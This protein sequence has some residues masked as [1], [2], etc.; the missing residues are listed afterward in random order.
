MR[1]RV[2]AVML[3]LSLMLGES[4]SIYATEFGG[5]INEEYEDYS[6]CQG[7]IS[8]E[9]MTE[10]PDENIND[11][12]SDGIIVTTDTENGEKAENDNS[13]IDESVEA[14][15]SEIDETSENG[16]SVADETIGTDASEA[17]EV[18]ENDEKVVD[19][20]ISE[21]TEE[22]STIEE[23]ELEGETAIAV[24]SIAFSPKT[25]IYMSKSSAA[26]KISVTY[27]P[28]NANTNTSVTWAS[29]N[30]SVAKVDSEGNVSPVG[31]GVCTITAKTPN[32]KAASVK[33]H[34]L[35][36]VDRFGN[37]VTEYKLNA[38]TGVEFK[39]SDGLKNYPA[40]WSSKNDD[41][42]PNDHVIVTDNGYVVGKNIGESVVTAV[43]ELGIEASAYVNVFCESGAE[44]RLHSSVV[45]LSVG[46]SLE[47]RDEFDL[48]ELTECPETAVYE[49]SVSDETI[50]SI[51]AGKITAQK[52]GT[53]AVK[54]K[55]NIDSYG[56]VANAE[57]TL[58]VLILPKD[59]EIVAIKG[60]GKTLADYSSW[61]P[62][63]WNWANPSTPLSAFSDDKTY[64]PTI[65]SKS[66]P[67]FKT[68]VPFSVFNVEPPQKLNRDK[69]K[70]D[71][72]AVNETMNL[73]Y[74]DFSL[75]KWNSLLKNYD[76]DD[77]KPFEIVKGSEG[78]IEFTNNYKIKG[79]SQGLANIN[80]SAVFTSKR[81]GA[82]YK[83]TKKYTVP[84]GKTDIRFVAYCDDDECDCIDG[85]YFILPSEGDLKLVNETSPYCKLT[86][87]SSDTSVL[88]IGKT[89]SD[90]TTHLTALSAGIVVI[91]AKANDIFGTTET[92]VVK[93][94]LVPNSK[95]I[96][97][98]TYSID[99]NLNKNESAS[100]QVYTPN[101]AEIF[102]PCL[103]DKKG[104]KLDLPLFC[105]KDSETKN[106]I[107]ISPNN[108]ATFKS[109][110]AYLRIYVNNKEIILSTP[111][112][113]NVKKTN[114]KVTFKQIGKFDTFLNIY[115]DP[116]AVIS[117]P[118]EKIVSFKVE[119]DSLYG[120]EVTSDGED[121]SVR[122]GTITI[123]DNPDS[124]ANKSDIHLKI[125]LADY[126]EPIDFRTK[127]ITQKSSAILSASSGKM[128]VNSSESK[129]KADNT[130][131]LQLLDKATK[132][133]LMYNQWI[134]CCFKIYYA[135][136]YY[137]SNY[138]EGDEEHIC[139][140]YNV[141]A[142]SEGRIVLKPASG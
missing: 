77:A 29:T 39:L 80:Y 25:D 33:I 127:V 11:S 56:S 114:P 121:P 91:T 57:E 45:K 111:I 97:L 59:Y 26:Q 62:Q 138:K 15:N 139:I 14:G 71:E 1:K 75:Q 142:D 53:A 124:Y 70:T 64:S 72:I 42:F 84:V 55:A 69:Y 141:S 22:S 21:D 13:E 5:G 3:A 104:E 137:S 28:A 78:I 43:S 132:R 134:H 88:K 83:I 131:K 116:T 86:Y 105:G 41:G 129:F 103:V 89:D 106:K 37:E 31:I 130:I 48:L 44:I 92:M 27:T 94:D 61:L 100:I 4:A 9:S 2:L 110:S 112:K 12:L 20:D 102:E 133:P 126:K 10:V 46:D 85:D 96:T 30:N 82:S 38:L 122:V 79:K 60:W 87:T 136:Y 19:E 109:T 115:S 36:L 18:I 135:D 16:S 40:T 128:Y 23:Y 24:Q 65:V 66:N 120:F 107:T 90:G 74:N 73:Q 95:N 118:G 93:T 35:G 140:D 101:D 32:G 119:T 49:Y 67:E 8:D 50:L 7:T 6:D 81:T 117:V 76:I 58:T 51:S 98:S 52:E 123:R 99:F 17:D 68:N 125:K 54:I 34:V 113:I 47:L 63:G 108:N